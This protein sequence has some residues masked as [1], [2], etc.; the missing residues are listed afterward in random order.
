MGPTFCRVVL[1]TLLLGVALAAASPASAVITRGADRAF[2]A[3]SHDLTFSLAG[4]TWLCSPSTITGTYMNVGGSESISAV[5]NDGAPTFSCR[6]PLGTCTFVNNVPTRLTFSVTRS[7]GTSVS[8]ALS[9][10]ADFTVTM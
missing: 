4:F 8:M 7:T 9:F 1:P 2:T 3:T 5:F 10:D 6:G